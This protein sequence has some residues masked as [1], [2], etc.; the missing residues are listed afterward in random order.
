MVPAICHR[1]NNA[2]AVT[3]GM[4]ELALLNPKSDQQSENLT[5]AF[6]QSRKSGGQLRRL[7]SFAHCAPVVLASENAVH[8][9]EDVA[10]LLEPVCQVSS[11]GFENRVPNATIP[12]RTDRRRLMQ[13]LLILA[14][15]PLT[16]GSSS[17][18]GVPESI[19][20]LRLGIEAHPKGV[21]IRLS[22]I[23]G[24]RELATTTADLLAPS[25]SE[26]NARLSTR[27]I[28]SSTCHRLLVGGLED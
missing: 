18:G 12:A 13:L 26:V 14:C 16:P 9:L 25:M 28:G 20:K 7:G 3:S 11:T 4:V 23:G 24:D 21:V 22:Y 10:D 17:F 15:S 27:T 19:P 5:L 1:L 8:A 2:V 6:E